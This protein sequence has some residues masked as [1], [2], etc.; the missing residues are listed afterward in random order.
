MPVTHFVDH[1]TMGAEALMALGMGQ[2]VRQW[3]SRHPPRPHEAPTTGIAI[4]SSWRRALGDRLCHGDWLAHLEEET[5]A[6]PFPDVLAR[7]IPRFAHDVGAY[8][9]HGLIRTAHATRA[10]E[11]MDTPARRR[12]L[13]HGLAL[14]AI[15]VKTAPSDAPPGPPC[16]D[17]E[18]EV[19]SLA[20]IGA[21][22]FVSSPNVPNVHLVTG[23]MAYALVAPYL[24]AATHRIALGSFARTHQRAA[25]RMASLEGAARRASLASLDE[26]RLTALASQGDAHPIKLTEAARR[27]HEQSGDDLFLRAAGKALDLHGIRAIL[28]AAKA[29]LT[30]HPE[31]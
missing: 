18:D 26:R 6:D 4:E 25:R 7:W 24:D 16:T 5:A 27:A 17:V 22:T 19:S 29:V 31:H 30:L 14:W 12:E 23:P 8:L 2:H 3:S 21:T 1:T 28:S 10:L 9:F 15:G 20:R 13:A 11:H